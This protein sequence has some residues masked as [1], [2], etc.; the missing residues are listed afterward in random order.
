MIRMLLLLLLPAAALIAG[1]TQDV[2]ADPPA[3]AAVG[4]WNIEFAESSCV[5]LRKF[6]TGTEET[7]F[8]L[9]TLPLAM[10]A[11]LLLFTPEAKAFVSRKPGGADGSVTIAPVARPWIV[12]QMQ[13]PGGD[14]KQVTYMRIDRAAIEALWTT[15]DVTVRLDS[16]KSVRVAMRGTA[17]I[18]VALEECEKN[19]LAA[20][21]IDPQLIADVAI[22][23][24]PVGSRQN[25]F[26]GFDLPKE[27]LRG[28]GTGTTVF[29]MTIG[30]DGRASDC[31][32]IFSSGSPAFDD[33]A[34][35]N[36]AKRA[37][38]IPA[39]TKDGTAVRYLVVERVRYMVGPVGART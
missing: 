4:A 9:R 34:C 18:K 30:V 32:I 7:T 26:N 1:A 5:A 28:S 8:V 14:G 27:L 20:W 10:T 6:G 11:E 19:L 2:P 22:K 21:K 16:G 33:A 24:E 3:L 13:M 12:Q 29:R 25:W 38:Y 17:A 39:K 15:R 36:V 31:A 23:P 37:R 35:T